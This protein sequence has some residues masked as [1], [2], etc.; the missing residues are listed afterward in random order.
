M[1]LV[2]PREASHRTI[3]TSCGFP[4]IDAHSARPTAF[5]ARIQITSS[6]LAGLRE[7]IA[8]PVRS[9]EIPRTARDHP[10]RTLA[11]RCRP[12]G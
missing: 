7:A 8:P 9:R 4:P 2:P 1:P 5:G 10:P 3:R 11:A 12:S 6:I